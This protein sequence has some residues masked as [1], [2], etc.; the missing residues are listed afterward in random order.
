M[1]RDNLRHWAS[2]L[3]N[4]AEALR[5]KAFESLVD[6]SNCRRETLRC[7]IRPRTFVY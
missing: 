1:A 7:V 3:R 5:I 2:T 6:F 4:V